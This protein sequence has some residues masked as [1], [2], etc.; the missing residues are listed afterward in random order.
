[1]VHGVNG[2]KFP[3][4]A[5][6]KLV[7]IIKYLINNKN[8]LKRI[9]NNQSFTNYVSNKQHKKWLNEVYEMLLKNPLS[10]EE[11]FDT[12]KEF[13]LNDC[14]IH[15]EKT[16]W[17]NKLTYHENKITFNRYLFKKG[18]KSLLSNG[19]TFTVKKVLIYLGLKN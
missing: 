9:Q 19:L 6:G 8:V 16:S 10:S 7:D 14:N 17:L 1:V 12:N 15:V 3:L 18:V 13:S 11:K 2:Y 4:E 5:P